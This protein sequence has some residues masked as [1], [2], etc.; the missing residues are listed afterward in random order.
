[1]YVN[2]DTFKNEVD[3]LRKLIENSIN[4]FSIKNDIKIVVMSFDVF[5]DI[6]TSKIG[7]RGMHLVETVKVF[8]KLLKWFHAE[9]AI[10]DLQKILME[11]HD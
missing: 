1:M 11:F 5:E 3:E 8:I 9:I 7:R 2:I 4:E 10:M 6:D